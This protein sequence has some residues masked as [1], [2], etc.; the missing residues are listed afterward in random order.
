MASP[1]RLRKYGRICSSF[2][3]LFF[4]FFLP[5]YISPFFSAFLKDVT[6][7]ITI[8]FSF[9][10]NWKT[11]S[12]PFCFF[13]W[14]GK[15]KGNSGLTRELLTFRRLLETKEMGISTLE[16]LSAIFEVFQPILRIFSSTGL[17]TFF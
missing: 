6:I 8:E 16:I 15:G 2:R 11:G 10:M 3:D 4:P 13:W 5:P 9:F 7:T 17:K 1:P 14:R 12:G